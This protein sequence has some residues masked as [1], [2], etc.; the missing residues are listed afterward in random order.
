M[1][2]SIDI[3]EGRGLRTLHFDGRWM[4][5]AMRITRPW[6]LELEYTQGDDGVFADAR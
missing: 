6:D 2:F 4:Q 5:G 3:R 1:D